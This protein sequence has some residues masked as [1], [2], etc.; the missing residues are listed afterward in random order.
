MWIMLWFPGP[1]LKVVLTLWQI[2]FMVISS[3]SASFSRLF[4]VSLR[5][6]SLGA[7]FTMLISGS[8]SELSSAEAGRSGQVTLLHTTPTH[9]HL[10]CVGSLAAAAVGLLGFS[11]RFLLF[12]LKLS[13]T[14]ECEV[15]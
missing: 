5:S 11:C 15:A 1:D 7:F 13:E 9:L 2:C 12:R 8:S 4:T 10:T 6:S 14:D 3:R